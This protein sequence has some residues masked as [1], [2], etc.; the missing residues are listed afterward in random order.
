EFSVK[1]LEGTV[2]TESS[3]SWFAY[4]ATI[5]EG[6]DWTDPEVWVKANPSLGVTVKVDDLKRQIDEAKEMPA[7]QNAIRRLRLNEWTEQVTRWLDMSVWEEGGLPASTDWRI[8]KHELEE[9][10]QTLLGREC[11]GGLDLA[12]Y[13]AEV[14]AA[15]AAGELV[16]D[17][18]LETP[19]RRTT[20]AATAYRQ[21]FASIPAGLTYLSLHFNTPGD[22]EAINPPD[23]HLRTEEYALFQRPRFTN[24][25]TL[26]QNKGLRL[27]C[28]PDLGKRSLDILNR[29]VMVAMHPRHGEGEIADMIHN[30]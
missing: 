23:A 16:F 3:D 28:G 11:Y 13:D 26:P 4:I 30:I 2:P 18:V 9:L 20:D 12:R 19:W 15:R 6:D 14:A 21:M 27:T 8:V 22:F 10:E 5:D 17:I 29:T 7:Q 25:Y 24:P 1:A